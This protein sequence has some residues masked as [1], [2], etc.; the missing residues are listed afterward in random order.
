MPGW[1]NFQHI[2]KE[3]VDEASA[4]EP[5]VFVEIGTCFGRSAI[6]MAE[7][8]RDS[9]KPISFFT[10]DPFCEEL[11]EPDILKHLQYE[12]QMGGHDWPMEKL[13][14]WYID[15]C[16]VSSIAT[17]I[18]LTSQAAA[19]GFLNGSVD[20]VFID[21]DHTQKQVASDILEWWPK[22]KHER[23]MGGHDYGLQSVFVAVHET[24]KLPVVAREDVWM[25][26]K[27]A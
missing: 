24:L 23:W 1:C 4:T 22:L 3:R 13:T 7:C 27:E 25:A 16:G 19:A 15:Q 12:R 9:G 20:W 21:G 10:I 5:S 17:V 11:L 18:P 6:F 26:W 14:R 2:Y 8:I